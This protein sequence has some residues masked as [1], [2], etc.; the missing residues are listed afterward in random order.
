[1]NE[2]DLARTMKFEAIKIKIDMLKNIIMALVV[3]IFGTVSYLFVN[4]EKLSNIKIWTIIATA[5]CIAL[6]ILLCV[7]MLLLKIRELEELR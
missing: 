3:A 7:K 1:M 4:I 6:I 2:K 5:V